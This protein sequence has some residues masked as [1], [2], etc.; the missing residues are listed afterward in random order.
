MGKE[1]GET[2]VLI[3]VSVTQNEK[4]EHV[5]RVTTDSF[6]FFVLNV[7]LAEGLLLMKEDELLSIEIC[8]TCSNKRCP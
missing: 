6:L 7:K 4:R 3:T 5:G 2:R 1:K 8:H